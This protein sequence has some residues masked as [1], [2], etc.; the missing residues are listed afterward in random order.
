MPT[1]YRRRD[2]RDACRYTVVGS[3][4]LQLALNEWLK[5]TL[6]KPSA[7]LLVLGSAQGML[8]INRVLVLHQRA[9]NWGGAAK[10]SPAPFF[11]AETRR[12]G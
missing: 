12:T 3:L 9:S 10:P 4:T 11:I 1:R 8:I 5:L 6:L 7:P 2:A